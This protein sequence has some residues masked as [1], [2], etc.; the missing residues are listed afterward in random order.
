M[1]DAQRLIAESERRRAQREQEN[2]IA[3]AEIAEMEREKAVVAQNRAEMEESNAYRLRMLSIAQGMAVKSLQIQDN[4]LEGLVAQQA[5]VFNLRYEGFKHDRYIYNGLYFA[6]KNLLFAEKDTLYSMREHEGTVRS[7]AISSDGQNIFSAGADGRILKW[8]AQDTRSMPEQIWQNNTRNRIIRTTRNG[9]WLIVGSDLEGIQLFDLQQENT[10]PVL[11]NGHT[12]RVH[13]I[14][15]ANNSRFFISLGDD[16]TLRVNDFQESRVMKSFEVEYNK[17]SMSANGEI[18]ALSSRSGKIILLN[19][20]NVDQS[21]TLVSDIKRP[22]N[23]LAFHPTENILAVGFDDG[24]VSLYDVTNGLNRIRKIN[25]LSGHSSGISS[26]TFNEQANYLATGSFDGSIQIWDYTNLNNL[27]LVLND[28]QAQVWNITF[29]ADGNYL[30]AGCENGN[31]KIWPTKAEILS[32]QICD[33]IVRNM[34]REE[35]I[36]YVASDVNYEKTCLTEDLP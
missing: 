14:V 36:R 15:V 20:S 34:T 13:D 21:V 10:R 29:S 9:K 25:D 7:L 32:V 11:L 8:S 2:A 5:Y 31:I 17:M 22:I 23:A 6:L 4:Q 33:H 1:A 18:L 16:K 19:A 3:A 26:I 24:I 27:P 12:G 30:F 35:W 28:N